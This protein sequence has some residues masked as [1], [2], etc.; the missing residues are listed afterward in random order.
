[1]EPGEPANYV[2]LAKLYEDAGRYDEAEAQLVKARG[3]EAER[4]SVYT[5]L[6][7]Y[8]NRQG[9]FP[10]TI[11]SLQKAA[12]L[13]RTTP[14]ATTS[15]APTTGTRLARTSASLR[16]SRRITSSRGSRWRTRR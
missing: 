16:P 9:D 1:M 8:Y 3:P 11:D 13:P 12:D 2:P 5:N 7:A 14:R 15:S 6:A 4:P 10:K